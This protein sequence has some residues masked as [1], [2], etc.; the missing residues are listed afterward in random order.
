[1][2][3]TGT[4]ILSVRN[5]R[6]KKKKKKKSHD[7]RQ[8]RQTGFLGLLTFLGERRP[9]QKLLVGGKINASFHKGDNRK[10]NVTIL[11]YTGAKKT[12]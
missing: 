6:L 11:F 2:E 5:I 10:N 12:I 4:Q 3:K 8:N 9:A 1:M 7:T